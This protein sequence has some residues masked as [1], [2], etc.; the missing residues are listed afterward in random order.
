M[1][2][3]SEEAG[4]GEDLTFRELEIFLHF[5]RTE[6][7]GETADTLGHSV[8]LIQRAVRAL[9]ARLGVRLVER[10][11]RRLRLLHA[12]RVLADQ[13]ALVL[14]QRSHAILE[15]QRAAGR[16]RSLLSIGHNFSLGLD[17][18]PELV[19]AV[20]ASEPDIR[21][22]LRSGPT[23]DL[24]ADVLSGHLDTA[25][26][27]PP[28]IEPDLEI[29]ALPPEPTVLIVAADDPLAGQ[30]SVALSELRDRSFVALAA[31]AGSRQTIIQA[32]ARAGFLPRVTIETGDM[33]AIAG[34]VAAGLA[35]SI[36]PARLAAFG[37]P[38]IRAVALDAPASAARPLGLVFLRKARDR[39]TIALL[40][41]AAEAKF[42]IVSRNA[43][44]SG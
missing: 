26:V 18:V 37:H 2:N 42:A 29:L 25:I 43:M 22:S 38:G 31:E 17:L 27:S 41:K 39:K 19:K 4:A 11:G 8:A 1:L 35:I 12:G 7:L 20:Q 15:T 13:A 21:V 5:S 6:H 14:R 3:A 10:Q 24:I 36:V 32:C 9:E 16:T 34:I 44:K 28:P 40:R 33:A 30:D 23:N